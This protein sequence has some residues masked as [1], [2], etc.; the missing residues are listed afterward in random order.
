MGLTLS[1]A[2]RWTSVEGNQGK[3][4]Y[5][6][7]NEYI[8]NEIT[9]FVAEFSSKNPNESKYTFK[10]PIE[11]LS[12]NLNL[13]QFTGPLF[14]I[15]NDGSI[16]SSEKTTDNSNKSLFSAKKHIDG[17]SIRI[18]L[19]NLNYCSTLLQL[20]K[21]KKLNEIRSCLESKIKK[22]LIF[23]YYYYY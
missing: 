4:E 13:N 19:M 12:E 22:L 11:Y 5:T 16:D 1:R 10:K 15:N 21:D 9:Q 6:P 20:A 18:V 7:I 3:L 14:I 23:Y 2:A 17:K 8:L